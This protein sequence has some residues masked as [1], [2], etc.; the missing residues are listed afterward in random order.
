MTKDYKSRA[1]LRHSKK[2]EQRPLQE[3]PSGEDQNFDMT[4][5]QHTLLQTKSD[6]VIPLLASRSVVT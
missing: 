6:R 5:K 3:E 2:E 4:L 1:L